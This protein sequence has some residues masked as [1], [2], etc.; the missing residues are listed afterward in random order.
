MDFEIREDRELVHGL[1]QLQ[2]AFVPREPARAD[3]EGNARC[4]VQPGSSPFPVT[5]GELRH[6][7]ALT[8]RTDEAPRRQPAHDLLVVPAGRH[9]AVDGV[10]P[11]HEPGSGGADP[12]VSTWKCGCSAPATAETPGYIEELTAFIDDHG[13]RERVTLI[14][15][16]PYDEMPDLYAAADVVVQPSWREGLGL[17]ALEALASGTCLVATDVSGFDEFCVHEENALL[18][19]AKDS[20][21]LARQLSR[22]LTDPVLV[23]RLREGG[24]TT[25]K[26]YDSAVGLPDHLAAYEEVRSL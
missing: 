3:D 10:Q 14:F 6:V 13:L 18:W 2:L 16:T 9:E 7:D 23:K 11:V 12:P 15:D 8:D 26:R 4:R 5:G 25:V 19:T 22:A 20:R 1:E 17:S 21:S 24:L